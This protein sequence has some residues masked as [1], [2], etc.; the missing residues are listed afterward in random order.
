MNEMEINERTNEIQ[1]NNKWDNKTKTNK[2][3]GKKWTEACNKWVIESKSFSINL[4]NNKS[5]I[6]YILYTSPNF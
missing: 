6:I 5:C 4:Q 3:R 2:R 1:K